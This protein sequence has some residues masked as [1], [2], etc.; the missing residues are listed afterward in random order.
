VKFAPTD[1]LLVSAGWDKNIRIWDLRQERCAQTFISGE[2]NNNSLDIRQGQ[3]LCGC[4]PNVESGKTVQI[5]DLRANGKELVSSSRLRKVY[6]AKFLTKNDFL[7][8]GSEGLF[9]ATKAEGLRFSKNHAN[10][11]EIF[12]LTIMDGNQI[13]I[14]GKNPTDQNRQISLLFLDERL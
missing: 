8:A 7:L 3:V 12:G 14:D 13:V 11:R 1:N 9:S 10:A 5:F 6:K 4:S 2:I